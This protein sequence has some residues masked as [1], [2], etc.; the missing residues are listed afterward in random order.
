MKTIK[1][2]VSS[3]SVLFLWSVSYSNY[4]RIPLASC[5]AIGTSVP[6]KEDPINFRGFMPS[7]ELVPDSRVGPAIEARRRVFFFFRR[8]AGRLRCA[9]FENESFLHS[10]N[11]HELVVR[12]PFIILMGLSSDSYVYLMEITRN[13][14][15]LYIPKVIS[16]QKNFVFF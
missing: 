13:P 10:L 7:N 4:Y 12:V 9:S 11:S 15:Y 5:V 8:I 2:K 16:I 14:R 3:L 6:H 1:G